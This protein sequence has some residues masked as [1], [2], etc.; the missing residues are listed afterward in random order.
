[1]CYFASKR[2]VIVLQEVVVVI[3][4]GKLPLENKTMQINSY[5]WY[6]CYVCDMTTHHPIAR[7]SLCS[8]SGHGAGFSLGNTGW[9]AVMW[10][11]RNIFEPSSLE[12]SEFVEKREK[13]IEVHK[14]PVDAR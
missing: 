3:I 13:Y 11:P 1:M 4:V 7:E 6:T 2:Q 8:R 5:V 12:M 10:A 9:N 14:N